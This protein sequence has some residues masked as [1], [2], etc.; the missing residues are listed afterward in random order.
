MTTPV[1]DMWLI[2]SPD[3]VILL[4]GYQ[5]HLLNIIISML[6]EMLSLLDV[7][8][9]LVSVFVLSNQN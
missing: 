1:I 4:Y 2:L 7:V 3:V 5:N 8:F 9:G 6:R